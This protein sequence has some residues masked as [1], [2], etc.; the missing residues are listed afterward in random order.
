MSQPFYRAGRLYDAINARFSFDI[1]FWV[2]EARAAGGPVLELACG[3]GR[4]TLPIKRAGVDITGLDLEPRMLETARAKAAEAGLDIPWVQGD[5]RDF[6]LERRFAL[7]FIP[8]N[9]L[10]HLHAAEDYARFFAAARR[11]LAPG[12]RLM[13]DVFNPSVAILADHSRGRI[14]EF[15]DPESGEERWIEEQRDYDA[16]TQV[17]RATWHLCGPDKPDLDVHALHLRC[18]FPQELRLM[19]AHHGFRIVHAWGNHQRGPLAS[20]SRFQILTL[21]P[22]A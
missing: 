2:E 17:N 22:E 21:E 16:L 9:S 3:T 1:D 14:A 10:L 6:S 4:L 11:H 8:F 18:L 12:G 15:K 20:D 5:I 13:L 19:A 7:V